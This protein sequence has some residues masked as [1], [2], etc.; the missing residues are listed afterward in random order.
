MMNND[1]N[2]RYIIDSR[3]SKINITQELEY[4]ILN[5]S[6]NTK[7]V[8]RRSLAIAAS[9]CLFILVSVPIMAA[10]IQP[11]NNLLYLIS[12]ETAQF[13]QPI[14][15]VAENNGIKMEVVAAMNDDETAI[16]YLT[17]QDLVG[18]RIDKT[19]DLYNYSIKGTNTFTH[20]LVNYDEDTKTATIRMIANGGHKLNGKKVIVQVDSFLS[21]KEHFENVNTEI[22]LADITSKIPKT[23][24]L[25]MH[26]SPG[27]GGDLYEELYK[28]GTI[29]ILKPDQTNI[30]LPNIDFVHI[31]NIGY[32]D[33]RLHVQTKWPDGIDKHGFL[34]LTN[35]TD[36]CIN[37]SNVY[38]GIDE[39][40]NTK[41]GSEYI[42][43]IF[44][45]APSLISN[46][47]LC[48]NFIKSNNYTEGKWQT[49]FKIKAVDKAKK[50]ANNINL[51][52]V[53]IENISITPIGITIEGNI[54][55]L[56]N[57]DINITLNN[58]TILSYNHTIAKES[59]GKSTVKYLTSSPIEIENIKE[60]QINGSV[61]NF[62]YK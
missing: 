31:S 5:S 54:S 21:G 32:I 62:N 58:G 53:K 41:Y 51:D 15:M 22:I 20:E 24:S 2:L 35:T 10:T 60:V 43:Y 7:K 50:I 14:E 16:V 6:H 57:I 52:N 29:N 40:G 49:T 38:F 18:D 61:V 36:G 12:P 59:N 39:N 47:S 28:E 9:I 19:V 33:G 1:K 23:I 46:Y 44:E 26:N 13:L 34:Y 56:D 37:P 3:L 11:F 30:T 8:K 42:E 25:N 4:K 45:V 55:D 27:G 17:L 48:G